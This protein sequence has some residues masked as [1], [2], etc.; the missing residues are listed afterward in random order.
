MR[1][2]APTLAPSL[3]L[4]DGIMIAHCGGGGRLAILALEIDGQ[5]VDAT[6]FAQR[7]G[8]AL[9]RAGQR[10]RPLMRSRLWNL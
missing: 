9:G 1:P 2:P 7:F 6:Q 8:A 5:A 4:H 10:P 3:S